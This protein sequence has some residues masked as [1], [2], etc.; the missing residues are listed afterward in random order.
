MQDGDMKIRETWIN[1]LHGA[2]TGT[3]RTRMLLTPVGLLVF[4]GFSAS[5]VL[6]AVFVDKAL[7]L[8]GLLPEAARIPLGAPTVAAGIIVTG[9]SA[10]H[11]LKVKGTPVPFNPPSKLVSTGPYRYARNPMLTGVFAFLFG[12]GFCL[13]SISL[14]VV[15]TPLY[16]LMNVWELKHIE[17]PELVRRLGDEYIEYRRMT[18]M[19]VP[20]RRSH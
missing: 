3:R 12:I 15:F 4:F 14:V 20:G 5:F 19:F 1:L 2:A 8:P 13:G 7:G 6:A 9:W 16:V 17:E 11:F 18:P 10:Y